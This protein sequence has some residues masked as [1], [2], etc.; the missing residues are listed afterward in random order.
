M[1]SSCST[2]EQLDLRA[3]LGFAGTALLASVV[4]SRTPHLDKIAEVVNDMLSRFQHV[5]RWRLDMN[6]IREGVQPMQEMCRDTVRDV[7]RLKPHSDNEELQEFAD[8]VV[9]FAENILSTIDGLVR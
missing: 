6:A 3:L 4:S 7:N 5:S 1:L 9:E 8:G 2:E